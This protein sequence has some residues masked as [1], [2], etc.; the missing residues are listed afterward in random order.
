[1]IEESSETLFYIIRE[2]IVS[3]L[4]SLPVKIRGAILYGSF[5]KGV[6]NTD[7]DIDILFVSDH[8]VPQKHRRAA[9]IARIKEHLAF[10]HP[11]DILLLTSKECISNFRNHNPLFLDIAWDGVILSDENN[12]LKNLIDETRSYIVKMNIIKL[13]D[14]WRFP[15][16]ERAP[17]FLSK[18]SNRD[19]ALAMLNDGTR[20]FTI[21][22]NIMEDGFYDKAVY[23]FQQATEKAVKAILICFGVF[24]RT[25]FVGEVLLKELELHPIAPMWKEKLINIGKVS[26]EAEPEVTW[27]R[28]PGIDNDALW[29]PYEEYKLEDASRLK[30][31]CE[32][33]I[34]IAQDFLAWWF[35]EQK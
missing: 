23:H 30:E 21:G 25:H 7:S 15:V 32:T 34:R 11:L 13:P 3:R 12:F 6:A 4:D 22:V 19:F 24:K 26:F 9:D 10:G 27:S 31:K 35:S 16:P 5:A 8:I 28:Y 33:V 17:V 20:D 29:I 18:V 1:M 14:G 2:H